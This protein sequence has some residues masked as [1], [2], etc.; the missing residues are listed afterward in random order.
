MISLR[1]LL[2]LT[3]VSTSV[4][5]FASTNSFSDIQPYHYKSADMY[6]YEDYNPFLNIPEL[7]TES[8]PY[9]NTRLKPKVI[10]TLGHTKITIST[11]KH[12]GVCSQYL[13]F[14]YTID[15][16]LASHSISYPFHSFP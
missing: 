14:N 4:F 6:F 12:L 5:T 16:K 9:Q 7:K 15:L 10:Y 8:F 3:F 11:R 13:R 2:L 1:L